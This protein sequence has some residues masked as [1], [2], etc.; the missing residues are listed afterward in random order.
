ML[1]ISP[2]KSE[3]VGGEG[4]GDKGWFEEGR[5]YREMKWEKKRKYKR[6]SSKQ[7]RK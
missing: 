3:G 4:E 7:E 2:L 6:E 5:G 1:S